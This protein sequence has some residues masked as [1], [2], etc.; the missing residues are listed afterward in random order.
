MSGPHRLPRSPVLVLFLA[1]APLAAA[2]PDRNTRFGLPSDAKTD[3]ERREDYLIHRPQY[4]LSYNAQTRRPNWVCWSLVKSD[5]G[6][7][8]RGPFEPDPLLPRGFARV[9]SHTYDGSGFDRGH[10]CP[11][12]DRSARQSDCD[13]TFF[14]TNIVPQSPASNQKAWERLE[15]YCRDLAHRGHELVIASG[16]ASKGGVGREGYKEEIGR[17]RVEVTVPAKVWKVVVVL[18]HAGAE[19]TARTRVIA[20]VMPNDQSVGFDWGAYRVR[21][22]N[23]ERLAGLRFFR[24]LPSEV[25]DALRDHLDEVHVP[26]GQPRYEGK[27]KGPD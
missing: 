20:V 5:I 19:P 14:M 2:E 27:G 8:E 22:R 3:P 9:T 26:V 17:G 21:A 25:A 16:P 24:D 10:M 23:V 13:A 7:A 12:K 15:S 4:T 11:S 18:P 1:A 6:H